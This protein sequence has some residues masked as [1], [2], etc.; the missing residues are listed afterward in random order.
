ME[1]CSCSCSRL[2]FKFRSAQSKPPRFLSLERSSVFPVAST[3]GEAATRQDEVAAAKEHFAVSAFFDIAKCYECVQHWVL[4]EKAQLA[5]FP[6]V[7][8]RLAL[9]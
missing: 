6:L 1:I 7:L 9:D 4:L 2:T 8:V 5:G 3:A